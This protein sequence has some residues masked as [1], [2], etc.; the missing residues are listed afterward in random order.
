ML[1]AA[2]SV[3]PPS[4]TTF[5][6]TNRVYT[7]ATSVHCDGVAGFE[8]Y[9]PALSSIAYRLDKI[10]EHL[11]A[12]DAT[13]VASFASKAET[14]ALGSLHNDAK[15]EA[16]SFRELLL[17]TGEKSEASSRALLQEIQSLRSEL[18]KALE[19]NSDKQSEHSGRAL[20]ANSQG[21]E[22]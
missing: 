18:N 19:G 2:A 6:N 22:L 11:S 20:T 10:E 15:T 5:G 16:A 9:G 8:N 1:P 4:D 3:Y 14:R 12:K 17:E 21:K 13:D 7:P